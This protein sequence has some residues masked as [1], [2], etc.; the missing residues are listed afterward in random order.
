MEGVECRSELWINH[1]AAV[2][3][4][5]FAIE[6]FSLMNPNALLHTHCC[7]SALGEG[8]SR[9]HEY[10]LQKEFYR[11]AS[12]ILCKGAFISP[13]VGPFH[14]KKGRVD[15]IIHNRGDLMFE[16]VC[17]SDRLVNHMDRLLPDGMYY[18]L[19]KNA[20]AW[21]LIDV[22]QSPSL[23][24]GLPPLRA[25]GLSNYVNVQFSTDFKEATFKTA[26]GKVVYTVTV[27]SGPANLPP[28][29]SLPKV[30]ASSCNCVYCPVVPHSGDDG[31]YNDGDDTDSD[32]E[33]DWK[34]PS[35]KRKRKR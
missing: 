22:W 9:C 20:K 34:S 11:A 25:G 21:L 24:M 16:L 10:H 2:T 12:S 30:E 13:E 29:F 5:R 19:T 23:V 35:H 4:L 31:D 14:G 8:S 26:D 15:F 27:G 1:H 18:N 6:C 17:N 3:P 33:G 28:G 7:R 32:D